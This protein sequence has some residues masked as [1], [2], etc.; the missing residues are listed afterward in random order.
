MELKIK[1]MGEY[2]YN[3]K[4]ILLIYTLIAVLLFGTRWTGRNVSIDTVI[5][6]NEP[7]TFYNWLDIGRRKLIRI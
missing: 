5:F 3:K 4:D 6:A 7:K 1:K 2:I